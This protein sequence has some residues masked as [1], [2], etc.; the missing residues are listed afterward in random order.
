MVDRDRVSGVSPYL[1]LTLAMVFFA[2]NVVIGRA[3]HA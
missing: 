1:F 3:V 2:T